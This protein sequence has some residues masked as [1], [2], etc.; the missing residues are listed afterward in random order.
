ML[1][2][3][4]KANKLDCLGLAKFLAYC[5]ICE[6][7]NLPRTNTLVNF[8]TISGV[9]ITTLYCLHNLGMGPMRL[10]L[11]Y[12]RLESLARDEHC[13]IGPIHKLRRK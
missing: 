3:F 6:L 12:I 13:L 5:N 1:H 8:A 4:F 2:N 11:H 9:V 10:V 7:I